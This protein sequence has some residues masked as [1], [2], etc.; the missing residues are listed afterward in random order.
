MRSGY[1]GGLGG[2]AGS[3]TITNNAALNV[4][5]G[6]T[7]FRDRG[8]ERGRAGRRG[9]DGTDI[10]V[11]QSSNLWLMRPLVCTKG[12]PDMKRLVF[13]SAAVKPWME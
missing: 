4:T 9:D 7:P 1:T 10:R 3:V 13:S 2:D 5:G 12:A 11:K 6:A 8:A